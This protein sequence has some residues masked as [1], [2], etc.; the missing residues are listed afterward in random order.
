MDQETTEALVRALELIKANKLQEAS[1]LLAEVIQRNPS[2]ERA[3]HMLSF[4]LTDREKQIYALQRVLQLNPGNRAARSQLSKIAGLSSPLAPPPAAPLRAPAMPGALRTKSP[5]AR[6]AWS[7]TS[8]PAGKP[9]PSTFVRVAKYAL[10][11]AAVLLLMVAIGVYLAIIVLNYGGY[12]DQ[13]ARASVD[14]AMN[15]LSLGMRDLTDAQRDQAYQQARWA[16][17]EAYGLH[18]PFLLRC[19]RWWYHALTLDWGQA[20]WAITREASNPRA[21]VRMIIFDDLPNTLLLAGMANLLL[22]FTGIYLS[23]FL[24]KKHGSVLDRIII[25]LS[26]ISSVPNWVY[27]ILLTVIFAGELHILPFGGMFDTF[28]PSTQWGYIPI[29]LKHMIL[30]VVAIFLSVF[31]QTV[32]AWRTFFLIHAGEDYLEMAKAQGLPSRMIERRYILKPVLPYIMTSFTL[33][34]IN[35]WQGILVLEL[36][37]RWPGIGRLFVQ[38]IRANDRNVTVGLVVL[39]AFLLAISVFVLDILY[40]L[41]DPR[42][43]LESGRQTVKPVTMTSRRL[44]PWWQRMRVR[45]R[46]HIPRLAIPHSNPGKGEAVLSG[47][48]WSLKRSLRNLK[49]TLRELARYPSAMVGL[50]VIVILIGISIYTVFAI[51]Y[52]VAVVRWRPETAEKYRYPKNALPT[53][54]NFFRKDPLPSTIIQNSRDGTVSKIIGPVSNGVTP[55]TITFTFDYP[56]SGFPQDL[57]VYFDVS[58]QVKKPFAALA[59]VA[60]DSRKLDLG[61]FS[62]V[63]GQSWLVSQDIPRKYLSEDIRQQS[64][65]GAGEGGY[66]AAQILFADPA[67]Q[68]PVSLQGRYTLQVNGFT[69]EEG[70]TL[71]AELV[72]YGQVYGWAGTD[73]HRRDLMVALL[74]GAPVALTFGFLG[75]IATSILSML[76]AAVGAWFG[77]RVDDL[78]QRLTEVNMILPALPIAIMVFYLYSNS[79]WVILGVMVL[80]SVFGSTIKSYRA[81]FLQVKESPYIEA[82]QAYGAGHWRIIRHYLLPRIVPL[83]IPQMVVLIPSYVFF[84]A[85]LA[86][87]NISDPNLPTWGKVVYDALTKGAFAGYYYWVLEPISLMMLTGLAFAMVGF[88]LDKIL[89]PRLRST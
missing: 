24:S 13:I 84:E 35:F 23:V 48:G 12:I 17:E 68:T 80:F 49:P 79:V 14:E 56:Y 27:G 11:R 32:Y 5:A 7:S 54:T 18:E 63:T 60:P 44:R 71:D 10:V 70:S 26:P 53:W 73:N 51:P 40:A 21:D 78:I 37:F 29:V 8:Q 67:A 9:L 55:I 6:P 19:V 28:P 85:T 58:Y 61:G 3:W 74:W 76:L 39:F 88:A 81:A 69:F 64:P 65:L 89:N 87:L 72:L 75:A 36:F 42:I 86:Y 25:T 46:V 62:L 52:N 77:G 1:V 16:M 83:L 15:S 38:A 41:V 31:F 34:L 22:F 33:M 30:P 50:V 4:A 82:A 57:A 66:P 45:P 20:T 43:R 2:S 59:W 47:G